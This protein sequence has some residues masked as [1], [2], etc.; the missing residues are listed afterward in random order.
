MYTTTFVAYSV[1]GTT[2]VKVGPGNPGSL[3]ETFYVRH[4]VLYTSVP[5]CE[6]EDEH[7][8]FHDAHKLGAYIQHLQVRPNLGK[9]IILYQLWS[10]SQM[11]QFSEDKYFFYVKSIPTFFSETSFKRSRLPPLTASHYHDYRDILP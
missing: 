2:Y 4:Q 1:R 8:K 10:D 11:S 9:H 5:V 6:H 7:H 3:R